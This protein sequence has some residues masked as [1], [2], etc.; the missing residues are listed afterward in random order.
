MPGRGAA[1]ITKGRS[2]TGLSTSSSPNPRCVCSRGTDKLSSQDLV[3]YLV[4]LED[5]PWGEVNKGGALTKNGLAYRLRDFRITPNSI[6]VG[7]GRGSPTP[8]GYKLGQFTDA[9]ARYLPQTHPE[10]DDSSDRTPDSAETQGFW[11]DSE[12]PDTR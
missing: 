8:K 6:Q 9:F 1:T 3:G 11:T 2:A 4:D 12:T 7:V 10:T 5:R